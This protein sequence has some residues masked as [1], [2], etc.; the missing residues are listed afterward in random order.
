MHSLR[1]VSEG[2]ASLLPAQQLSLLQLRL[3]HCPFL[4]A[5]CW[6]IVALFAVMS[7]C[8]MLDLLDLGFW[9]VR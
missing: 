9:R 8:H 7:C 4:Q 6:L 2:A 5:E 1:V 3:L